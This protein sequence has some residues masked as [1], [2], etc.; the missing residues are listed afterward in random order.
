M[1]M[2]TPLGYYWRY[3]C[4]RWA[5]QGNDSNS[6]RIRCPLLGARAFRLLSRYSPSF[7]TP[8]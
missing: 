1:R 4:E 8:A 5:D 3:A 6:L 7:R 2:L